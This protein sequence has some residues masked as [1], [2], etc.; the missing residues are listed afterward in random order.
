MKKRIIS[1][2]LAVVLF[3]ALPVMG[4]QAFAAPET[5]EYKIGAETM[6]MICEKQGLDYDFCKAA[7]LKLN[8]GMKDD[9]SDLKFGD[10]ITLPKT[11]QAAA[12]ILGVALPDRLKPS[13][14]AT[15]ATQD[16][17]VVD[18]DTMIGICDKLKL[19]FN[20]CKTA[21]MKLNNFATDYSFLTLKTGTKLKMP[22]T[23]AD[24]A[25]IAASASTGTATGSATSTGATGTATGTGTAVAGGNTVS[26]LVPHV[27]KLG[28]TIYGICAENGVDFSKYFDLIMTVSGIK[29]ATDLRVGNIVYL[30]S[31][32]SAT[33]AIAITAHTVK[34]GETTYGICQELGINFS[35]RYNM[36][37]ALNP[38]KNLNSIRTGDVLLFP[39]GGG[40]VP[41][42]GG[43]VPSGG[44]TVPSGGSASGSGY[45]GGYTPAAGKDS[46]TPPA[47]KPKEGV[48]YYITE[49]TVKKDDTVYA[50]VKAAGFDYTTYYADVLLSFNS[51]AN[52]NNLKEGDKLLM[53]SSSATGA[54]YAVTGVKV[55]D[56]DT[57]IKMC[58]DAGITYNNNVNLISKLNPGVNVNSI[59]TGDIIVLPKKLA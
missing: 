2:L 31:A 16:Y 22:K 48:M 19:D 26:Y 24:A 59:K 21:I 1:L 8:S 42:G 25:V 45:G 15:G 47:V 44:G 43:T 27:V 29:F 6:K 39:A 12:D 38:G 57:V 11:N 17:T 9:F 32:K 23:N 53:L 28:E 13:S 55:K 5:V 54:K 58:D 35:A 52:F 30:P 49:I 10:T 46:T 3:A 20:K 4:A 36:I 7:I 18:H 51:L 14:A 41:S 50:L 37:T 56:G 40:T 33:G 34:T